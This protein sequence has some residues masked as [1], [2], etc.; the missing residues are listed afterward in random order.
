MLRCTPMPC[1]APLRALGLALVISLVTGLSPAWA[2]TGRLFLGHTQ[3]NPGT[4]PFVRDLRQDIGTPGSVVSQSTVSTSFTQVLAF[5]IDPNVLTLPLVGNTFNVSVRVASVSNTGLRGR[6]R[7]LRVNS[8]GVT[9]SSSGYSGQF[10]TA[11]VQTASLV[12]GDIGF[13]PG[14]RLVLAFEVQC[15]GVF[16]QNT[17]T[18]AAGD[19]DSWIDY[20]TL[21]ASMEFRTRQSG[22]W[23]DANTWEQL[24]ENGAWINTANI[25]SV[26][27]P[28]L[29]HAGPMVAATNSSAITANSTAHPVALPGGIE[30]GDLLMVFWMDRT[31]ASTLSFPAGWTMMYEHVNGGRRGAAF[32]RV[33]NGTE[34]ATIM[35]NTSNSERSAHTSYRIA[36]GTYTGLPVWGN[37]ITSTSNQ[38]NPPA[39]TSGFGNV[40]SLWIAAAHSGGV[41]SS[42]APVNYEGLLFSHT[43]GSGNAHAHMSTATRM[44]QAAS[45]NPGPFILNTATSWTANTVAV[46]GTSTLVHPK[47][48]TTIRAGHEVKMSTNSQADDLVLEQ[49]AILAIYP[50]RTLSLR[51]YE[52]V[53]DGLLETGEGSTLELLAGGG[54]AEISTANGISLFNITVNAHQ[55]VTITGAWDVQGTLQ[56]AGGAFDAT[57]ANVRLI[58]NATR[59]GRLAPVDPGASYLG[60]LT[61]ERYIPGGVTNWRLLGSPVGGRTVQHWKD[62]FFTAGFPGSHYPNFYDPPGSG[63]L[64][65]S[66][67]HYDETDPGPLPTDGLIGVSS[68]TMPLTIGK[69]FA[70]WCGD[71]LGGTAPFII[72]LKG[73]PTIA[74]TPVTLPMSWTDTG[75]PTTDG[76]NLVSNPLPSPIAFSGIQLG[77]DVVNSFHVYDPVSGNMATWNG[78]VGNNGATGTIQS[79]QGFWLKANG[80]AVSTTVAE[81]A[82]TAD[83]SGGIF[84]GLEGPPLAA[85][86]LKVSN[87]MN[88][89]TDETI[90]VFASGS[91]AFNEAEGDALKFNFA[92]AQAPRLASQGPHGEEMAIRMEG[93]PQGGTAIP[94]L[95]RAPIAGEYTITATGMEGLNGLS[96]LVLEDLLTG[97]RTPL[98]EGATLSV[99]LDPNA[100]PTQPRL[101]LHQTSAL[102]PSVQH[103]SCHG[104]A[105]GAIALENTTGLPIDITWSDGEGDALA[106]HAGVTGMVS[107]EG[108]GAGTYTAHIGGQ[109]C[110]AQMVHLN[111][112]EPWA[113]ELLYTATPATCAE[114]TDGH[115]LLEVLGGT[116]PY[117]VEWSTGVTSN[118]LEGVPAGTYGVLVT[119]AN[120]CVIAAEAITVVAP[121]PIDGALVAPATALPLEA[122]PFSSTAA[123]EVGRFWDFGDGATSEQAA[124]WHSYMQPGDYTVTLILFDEDCDRTLSTSVSVGMATSIHAAA[125]DGPRA[126]S[127]GEAL[128]LEGAMPHD[129]HLHV[130]DATGRTIHTGRVPAHTT[131]HEIPTHGWT[132]GIYFLNAST[133]WQQWTYT[134]PVT[135]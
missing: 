106:I 55:G 69:G 59:T 89:F 92:H 4:G 133:V 66:V 129:L 75:V 88:T 11:G 135:H 5:T 47:S 118:D 3:E 70:A 117:E 108:L 128:V 116:W 31:T 7:V 80:P 17:F 49:G 63:N 14:D 52:V 40:A 107:L 74:H 100:D 38:P 9:Q 43:G 90:V 86:Y 95:V 33:A 13:T 98:H 21:E 26:M 25:P 57:N 46:R 81:S 10:T 105:D 35:A 19:P 72:D 18:V 87:D 32:Y 34:G 122:V 56:L 126:W 101:L 96:C 132:S 71:N 103:V 42:I 124:P 79:S 120:G 48:R 30:A 2:Q 58:S 130:Y 121:A 22:M 67:R 109:E 12:L 94:L 114:S 61:V 77:A 23:N 60:N 68:N 20:G 16:P 24:M 82:K 36:A 91:P 127:S 50:S 64:W 73:P 8:S 1:P 102:G 65:P 83:Q 62:D 97:T 115:V 113:L 93:M 44:F 76:W 99:T 104:L 54:A 37:V 29:E 84:G 28:Y 51:G 78:F 134:L 111:V 53:L 110:P 41:N 27:D 15:N 119:D 131:R 39:L 85:L 123:P 112:E 125:T 6:Y 45:E